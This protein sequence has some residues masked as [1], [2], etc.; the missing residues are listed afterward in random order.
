VADKIRAQ[1]ALLGTPREEVEA[2]ILGRQAKRY[3]IREEVKEIET[4]PSPI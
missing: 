4:K 1:S 2:E 3:T